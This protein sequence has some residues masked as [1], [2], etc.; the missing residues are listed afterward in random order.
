[1]STTLMNRI[2]TLSARVRW[3]PPLLLRVVLGVTFVKASKSPNG[4]PLLIVG[5]EVSG[6][7][8]IYQ[9][10]LSYALSD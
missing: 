8:A 2:A 7:T 4:K 3:L 6:T 10:N 9:L 5:N 1:M